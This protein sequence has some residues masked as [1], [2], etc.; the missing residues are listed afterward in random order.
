MKFTFGI[1]LRLLYN[2]FYDT[3]DSTVHLE[4]IAVYVPYKIEASVEFLII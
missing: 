1:V 3:L 4:H 2:K